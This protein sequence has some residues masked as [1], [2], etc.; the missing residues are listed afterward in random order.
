VPRNAAV[1]AQSA[2]KAAEEQTFGEKVK[3]A[4]ERKEGVHTTGMTSFD[5][6]KPGRRFIRPMAISSR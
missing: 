2:P 1:F 5:Q 3:E 6:R 4:V